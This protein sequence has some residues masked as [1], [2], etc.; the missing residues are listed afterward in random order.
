[1]VTYLQSHLDL[2]LGNAVVN[3]ESYRF[4]FIDAGLLQTRLAL[5]IIDLFRFVARRGQTHGK[6]ITQPSIA[7]LLPLLEIC[8]EEIQGYNTIACSFRVRSCLP[9]STAECVICMPHEASL[10]DRSDVKRKFRCLEKRLN[11]REIISPGVVRTHSSSR[12]RM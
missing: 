3:Q 12:R 4:F 1:M 6:G 9:A 11:D 7:H 10:G 5:L 8:S 2:L